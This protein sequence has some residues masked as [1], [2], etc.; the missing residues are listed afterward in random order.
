[1]AA[2][3][4]KGT[5]GNALAEVIIVFLAFLLWIKYLETTWVGPFQLQLVGWDFFAHLMMVV[6]PLTV[7]WMAGRPFSQ[8]GLDRSQ[9][10]NRH[11]RRLSLVATAELA[12]IWLLGLLIP[13]LARG[14]G[15]RLVLPPYHFALDLG[16]SPFASDLLGWVL[17]LVF[18]MIFCGVGEEVFFRGYMQGRINQAAGRRFR[19]L[20]I[21]FGWGLLVAS[22][23]FGL[24]HG[25]A[26]FNPFARPFSFQF[27]WG[28][29]LL[30]CVEGVILGLLYEHTNG[31]VAP[32]IVHA[33]IGFFFG[34]LAFS[35]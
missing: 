13:H 9:F 7:T 21:S 8:L 18:T 24:G 4:G 12:L 35:G 29:A 3:E 27:E 25:L 6:F 28:S 14:Q 23:L 2:K 15:L 17:T 33:T 26:Y 5:M 34:S 1:M 10:S 20:G 30:T 11:V 32:A 19:F 22:L 16:F 31:I